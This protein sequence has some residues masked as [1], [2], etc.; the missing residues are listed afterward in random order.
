MM[1]NIYGCYWTKKFTDIWSKEEDFTTDCKASGLPVVLTDESFRTLYYLLYAKYGNSHIAS[2]DENQFRYEMYTY[3]WKYGGTWQKK[4]EIQERLRALT[5]EEISEGSKQIYNKALN[6]STEP[7]TYTSEE[8]AYVNDQTVAKNKRGKLEGYSVLL[9]LLQND[10][11]DQFL[12]RF[13]KLFIKVAMPQKP[14]WYVSD[15]ESD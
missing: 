12:N 1:N 10:V 15:E 14:L 7:G 11:T 13:S 4:V 5:D 9:E 6:P 2:S 8:L 3:I